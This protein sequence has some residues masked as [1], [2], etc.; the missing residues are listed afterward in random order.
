MSIT[1]HRPP[2]QQPA[3]SSLPRRFAGI[4]S[5]IFAPAVSLGAVIFAAGILGGFSFAGSLVL[6]VG[7]AFVPGLV[8][9]LTK[10]PF[11]RWGLPDR[12]RTHVLAVLFLTGTVVSLSLDFDRPVPQTVIALFFGNIGLLVWRRWLDVSGH[13]SVLTFATFWFTSVYGSDLAWLLVLSPLMLFS[14]VSL[15]EHTW[16][17]GWSG[18]ALGLATFLC[19]AAATTWS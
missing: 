17:E 3:A 11:A 15:K 16:L 5:R 19:Y 14:R 10:K 13:V 8:Y 9:K 7:L 1:Q 12:W 4:F 2:Q 6:T 18:A